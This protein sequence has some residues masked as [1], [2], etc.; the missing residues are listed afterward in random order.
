MLDRLRIQNFKP[1]RDTGQLE[2]A[3]LTILFGPNS[4]GKSS[5]NHL[6]VMLKQTVRSSDRNSLFDLGDDDT[7][8]NLGSF[9][10]LIFG[11]DLENTLVR[12]GMA[13][14]CANDCSRSPESR[15]VH[16]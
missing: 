10:D 2:L 6:L 11:H 12:T 16:G 4:S 5:I 14:R 8:V 7:P 1:W 15:S 3:P 13:T 9:R